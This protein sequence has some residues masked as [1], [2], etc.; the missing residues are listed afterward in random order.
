MMNVHS[1]IR[2][3]VIDGFLR[4]SV[5]PAYFFAMSHPGLGTALVTRFYKRWDG[6][7]N[8]NSCR[9]LVITSAAGVP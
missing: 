8:G 2:D 5:A 1:G 9:K 3:K 7:Q 6:R 4:H